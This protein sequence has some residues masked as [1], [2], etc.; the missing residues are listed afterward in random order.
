MK[1]MRNNNKT[2]HCT[3]SVVFRTLCTKKKNV[4]DTYEKKS[5]EKNYSISFT[6]NLQYNS[7][8]INVGI[9]LHLK[10]RI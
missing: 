9:I 6:N 5:K 7:T 10:L 8:I 2:W 4:E 3:F 1:Y